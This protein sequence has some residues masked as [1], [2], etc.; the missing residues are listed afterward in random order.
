MK[1]RL[2]WLILALAVL[3][4]SCAV[5]TTI[6]NSAP[7]N[8]NATNEVSDPQSAETST[9]TSAEES[10]EV[11]IAPI[12]VTPSL[13]TEHTGRVYF[14]KE[15]KALGDALKVYADQNAVYR[16]Q[17]SV[18]FEQTSERDAFRS[19]CEN[20]V[21]GTLCWSPKVLLKVG[22]GTM[23]D[24]FGE[25]S[26]EELHA[27][28]AYEGVSVLLIDEFP[29]TLLSFPSETLH[30][31]AESF[32]AYLQTRGISGDG[33]SYFIHSQIGDYTMI[34]LYGGEFSAAAIVEE[35][36]AGYRIYSGSIGHPSRTHLYWVGNGDIYTISAAYRLGLID[37]IGEVVLPDL[38][39]EYDPSAE[40][41]YGGLGK[42][43][44]LKDGV[45]Q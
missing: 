38:I 19:E 15:G 36:Y 41:S 31:N 18:R 40:D 33:G 4:S 39:I 1:K 14:V 2:I 32:E 34:E 45:Y 29:E 35:V 20:G 25:L 8:S 3:L 43:V 17:I 24:L 23:P 6:T 21:F 26:V 5:A 7:E 12:V 28:E 16:V 13:V 37:D 30:S 44:E 9:D 22:V 27:L 11:E 10:S 42:P